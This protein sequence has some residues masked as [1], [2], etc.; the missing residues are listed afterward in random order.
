[1]KL[2]DVTLRDGG[3]QVSFEWPVEFAK[4]Y[5]GV[6][7]QSPDLE[8]T[9]VG[10]WKQ[11][12]K[13]T[14]RFYAVDEELIRKLDVDPKKLAVMID[15]HYCTKDL[16]SYPSESQHP[17]GLIRLTARH[18]SILDALSFLDQLKKRTGAL[19]SLN[20]F[21][22]SNYS[23]ESLK[24][25]LLRIGN[26]TPDFIYFADTHGALDLKVEG[27]RF[28]EYAKLIKKTGATPGFHLHNHVGRALSNFQQLSTLGYVFADASLNGLGKGAGNLQLEHILS[29][30]SITPL[31]DLWAKHADLFKMTRSPYTHLSGKLSSTDH[32]ADQ[33]EEL[34]LTPR[35]FIKFL[36][37]LNQ[38]EQDNFNS[39]LMRKFCDQST[40]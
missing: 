27:E 11:K 40:D 2:I 37:G 9:E 3:H 31:L 7:T 15:F 1:M 13:F 24:H 25:N 30:D 39:M 20:L 10:Y 33:A 21:N 32:Y 38:I 23:H 8:F 4:N 28:A 26:L 19:T 17:I 14:G 35:N 16:D 12:N 6:T 5:L 18:E 29:F 34:N 36:Q 22:I